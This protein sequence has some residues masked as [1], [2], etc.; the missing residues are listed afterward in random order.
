MTVHERALPTEM[1]DEQPRSSDESSKPNESAQAKALAKVWLMGA[2][3]WGHRWTSQLGDLPFNADG[4][5][6]M[7]AHLWAHQLAGISQ[8]HVLQALSHY[9][10][11]RDW[12]PSLAEIRKQALGIP[13]IDQVRL[14]LG[15]KADGFTRLV[16]SYIDAWAFSRADQR[17]AEAM[18]RAAYDYACERR[19]AGDEYPLALNEPKDLPRLERKPV[20]PET[21]AKARAEIDAMFGKGAGE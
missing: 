13:S 6:T 7:A 18:L 4:T 11:T 20:S 17:T 21:I 8:R 2:A 14:D 9:A 3:A 5:L 16:W 15:A 12:P 1:P 10:G 19:L